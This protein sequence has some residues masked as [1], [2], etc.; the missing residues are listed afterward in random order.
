MHL[1][2]MTQTLCGSQQHWIHVHVFGLQVTQYVLSALYALP[3]RTE[4]KSRVPQDHL[5]HS[6]IYTCYKTAVPMHSRWLAH[7]RNQA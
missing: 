4:L 2:V 6:N 5:L 1:R 7:L 3:Y